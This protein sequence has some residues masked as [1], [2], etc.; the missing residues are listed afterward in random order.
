MKPALL[1]AGDIA[2]LLV[3]VA[4]EGREVRVRDAALDAAAA[5][6]LQPDA[7]AAVRDTL[8]TLPPGAVS[9]H[10]AERATARITDVAAPVEITV[11][12]A[13]AANIA[14]SVRRALLGGGRLPSRLTPLRDLSDVDARKLLTELVTLLLTADQPAIALTGATKRLGQIMEAITRGGERVVTAELP[15]LPLPRRPDAKA[16]FGGL[17]A[18]V[19]PADILRLAHDQVAAADLTALRRLKNVAPQLGRPALPLPEPTASSAVFAGLA[20]LLQEALADPK[21]TRGRFPATSAED[22]EGSPSEGQRAAY[23]RLDA[24]DRVDPGAEFELRVGLAKVPS[25]GVVQAAPFL[26]PDTEFV[27]AVRV[28]AEGFRLRGGG[29]L[30]RRFTVSPTDP[31]PYDVLRLVALEDGFAQRR[32]ILA[33]YV[34]DGRSLGHAMRMVVVATA[35]A[36]TP[37]APD[38]AVPPG[39]V[40]VVPD[41]GAQPDLQITI[42]PGNDADGVQLVWTCLSRHTGLTV[43]SKSRLPDGAQWARQTMR[44]IEDKQDDEDFREH[45]LGV[46]DSIGDAVPPE[47]WATIRSAAVVSSPPTIL[48]ATWEPYLPWELAAA[49]A[50]WIPG[51]PVFLGAQATVGRWVYS[52]QT[53][54]A[55]PPAELAVDA[56]SVVTGRY[57]GGRALPE[58]EAEAGK[59]QHRYGAGTVTASAR[60]ILDC[61]E[62]SPAVAA[63][64]FALHGNVDTGGTDDGLLMADGEHY[65]GP[66][67]IRGV[68]QVL[69]DRDSTTR[70]TFLNACQV[71]QGNRMLGQYAGM[72]AAFIRLG[73]GAVVAPLWKV[74]DVVARQV[75]EAFYTAVFCA[76]GISPAE[77]LRLERVSTLGKEGSLAG[78]RLAYVY[79]GHPN[80]RLSWTGTRRGDD[81]G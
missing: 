29:S 23:A 47:I 4:D 63:L 78:T 32:M 76:D 33:E 16:W 44:T 40:W 18:L 81:D 31:F 49:P 74:D 75:A 24:P 2:P 59:I 21:P 42:A 11:S 53:H 34:V 36:A 79:F 56:I 46:A 70:V 43:A 27:L 69:K 41:A 60:T 38:D 8:A 20:D 14:G 58:A 19:S 10:V 26:V 52:E 57:S 9:T 51:A 72:A 66:A 39:S 73:V 65:L 45:L 80:L 25:A 6:P 13:A 30:D 50:P 68:R 77:Q 62:G 37:A 67:A 5:L 64:H 48:L 1:E 15:D 12:S 22:V 71:G 28:I 55:T 7:I 17:L 35:E 3:V 54:M 61:L